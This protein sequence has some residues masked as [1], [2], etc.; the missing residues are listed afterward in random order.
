MG[1][2]LGLCCA[3]L[4]KGHSRA[5]VLLALL[6]GRAGGCYGFHYVLLVGW[7]GGCYGFHVVFLHEGFCY[8]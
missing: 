5:K 3:S 4:A 1:V 7:A 6:I 8:C 2:T